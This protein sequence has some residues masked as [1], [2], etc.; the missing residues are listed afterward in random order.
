VNTPIT[1]NLSAT[2]LENEALTFDAGLL[3]SP[4]RATLSVNGSQVTVT[5]NTGYTGPINIIVGVRQQAAPTRFDTQRITIAV[6]DQALT[7]Q[8]VAVTGLEGIARNSIT[9]ATFTDADPN[10]RA[11]N[12]TATIN[13]GD[14]HASTGTIVPG[15]G[16]TFLVTGSNTYAEEGSYPVKVTIMDELGARATA[17]S[18]AVIDAKFLFSTSTAGSL[19]SSNG[20]ATRFA[21]SD[22]LH[23]TVG[24]N[25]QHTYGLYLDGSDIGL[26]LASEDID[27]FALLPDRSIVLS[28]LG[29]FSV[30]T[31]YRTAGRG[32]GSTLTGSGEDLLRFRPISLGDN[33]TGTWSM[34]FDGSDVGLGGSNENID[35]VAVL[36]DGR[37]LISTVGAVS[38]PGASGEDEDLL[39]FRPRRLGTNTAGQWAVYFDGSDLGLASSSEEDIDALFV[40]EASGS[41]PTVSVSTRGNFGVSG[42]AGAD[43]DAFS[44]RLT[45]TGSTTR[46]TPVR[47]LALDGDLYG[48]GR[49]DLD[50]IFVGL[51]PNPS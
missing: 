8:G 9:V 22:I 2:D 10:G 25:G 1:F 50:G 15:P 43:E 44:I 20:T 40:R 12:Y 18:T 19:V 21:N 48:L 42:L 34:Y 27:A 3:E 41:N 38:V 31:T 7:A 6:G 36:R 32:S 45:R 26:T 51:F 16:R 33:T 28:T 5:P 24:G 11:S 37:I 23:L 29:S 46:G 35:A 39:A 17:T 4:P 49:Y 13:W 14:G 30:R 47:R